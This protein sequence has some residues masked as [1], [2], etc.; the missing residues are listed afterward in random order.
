MEKFD[1][2]TA[3]V[4]T[5]K[6]AR[7]D[8]E[9]KAQA[10][11]EL[12]GNAR[13]RLGKSKQVLYR[14]TEDDYARLIELAEALSAGKRKKVSITETIDLALDALREKLAGRK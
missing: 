12:D 11:V 2:A 3:K 4:R 14:C 8:A 1:A 9:R 6:E 13:L 5:R 7:A 10:G